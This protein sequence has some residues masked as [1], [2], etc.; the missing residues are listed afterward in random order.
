MAWSHSVFRDTGVA[1]L[2][3]VPAG[4]IS[5]ANPAAH[6]LVGRSSLAGTD[7]AD[8]ITTT[9]RASLDAFL[10]ELIALP[11][12]RSQALGP[13]QLVDQIRTRVQMVGSRTQGDGDHDALVIAV[14]ELAMPP[15]GTVETEVVVDGPTALTHGR[16]NSDVATTLRELA[17]DAQRAR[18]EA[19]QAQ[20]EAARARAEADEARLEART[21]PMTG[22]PNFRAYGE[23]AQRLQADARRTGAPV[24][25]AF[26]D[27]DQF[28]MINKS[29][30]WSQGTRTLAA[31]ARVLQATCRS[32]DRVFRYG[33]E[34][35]VVLLPGTDLAGA[36]AV[37]ERMRLGVEAAGI[38][39]NGTP[40]HP[41]VTVSV[42][43]AS[44]SGP[45]IEIADLVDG[46]DTL[47]QR[48][49]ETGRNR[50]LPEPCPPT[51]SDDGRPAR[52]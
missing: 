49:K 11:A 30:T 48:A 44:G 34:E 42:G 9:D 12:G 43:V 4:R 8:L 5:V 14:Q 15:A 25:V 2:V 51:A 18:S 50:V 41:I 7:L 47:S 21:C 16:Q 52:S 19:A 26:V 10:A 46:A 31:V 17:S 28:G 1:Q 45:G 24:A 39:H 40:E 22:L 38:P 23:D 29:F 27:L 20:Q 3:V 6:T 35:F 13:V 32:D 36:R 37:A 33:G